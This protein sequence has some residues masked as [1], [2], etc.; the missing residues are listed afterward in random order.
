VPCI[1]DL[2]HIS[3]WDRRRS[4]GAR[5]QEY[6]SYF[7]VAQRSERRRDRVEICDKSLIQGTS[8]ALSLLSL[9]LLLVTPASPQVSQFP[10]NGAVDVSPDTRLKL[11]FST[12]PV[13]NNQGKARVYDTGTRMVRRRPARR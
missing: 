6:S 4:Q 3:A 8:T 5:P 2:S 9:S 11:T 10:G 13:M 1:S 12:A 7:K